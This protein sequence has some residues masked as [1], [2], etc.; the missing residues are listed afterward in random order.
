ALQRQQIRS[1]RRL[2]PICASCKKIR[3]DQGYWTEVEVY[4]RDQAGAT[5][6]HGICPA[7]LRRLYPELTPQPGPIDA[8]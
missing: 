3:D 4:F 5:F 1:L 6:T 7:C 8:G 2:L